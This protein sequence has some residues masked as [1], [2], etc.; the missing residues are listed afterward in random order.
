MSFGSVYGCNAS[1]HLGW[2]RVK[3]R[4]CAKVMDKTKDEVYY[5]KKCAETRGAYFCFADYRR[6]HG[7]C[8][9]CGAELEPV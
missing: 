3:C 2:V 6:L 1:G 5:C 7:K 9:F 8:P 4:I